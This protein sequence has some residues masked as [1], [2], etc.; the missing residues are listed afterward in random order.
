M[1]SGGNTI[2]RLSTQT[3]VNVE[4][5]RYYEKIGLLPAPPRT[6]GGH[7]IYG[8]SEARRLHFIR[9][10]RELGFSVS[11]IRSLLGLEDRPPSCAE[12]HA[13]T[14]RHLGNVRAKIA[15]LVELERTLS[16]TAA[17]CRRNARPKCPIIETL[18]AARTDARPA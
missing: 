7:R 13:L 17:A 5:I 1:T 6:A 12:V 10:A 3:G 2:G 16:K 18:S 4:T 14:M 9:R 8:R 11:D 15:D